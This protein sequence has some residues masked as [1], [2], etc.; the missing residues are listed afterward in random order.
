MLKKRPHKFRVHIP[1]TPQWKIDAIARHK[2]THKK[3]KVP[4]IVGDVED[5]EPMKVL[6]NGNIYQQCHEIRQE[7]QTL[8]TMRHS[9][10]WLLKKAV[11][12]ETNRNHGGDS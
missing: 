7:L 2:S 6:K 10:I 3:R 8:N 4:Q 1:L 11:L 12:H 5:L 9:L